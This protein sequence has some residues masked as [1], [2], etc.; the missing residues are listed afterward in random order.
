MKD[1]GRIVRFLQDRQFQAAL[2]KVPHC[3]CSPDALIPTDSVAHIQTGATDLPTATLASLTVT[4]GTMKD[5]LAF[6]VPSADDYDNVI[7]VLQTVT[8]E[9][10]GVAAALLSSTRAP[11]RRVCRQ[12]RCGSGRG[13]CRCRRL[14]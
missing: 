13:G 10:C 7:D 1:T 12:S 9:A 2:S 11:L 8:G 14:V 3:P 5:R 6:C 4:A